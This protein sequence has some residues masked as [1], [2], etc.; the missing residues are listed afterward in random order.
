MFRRSQLWYCQ[1]LSYVLQTCPKS[2][3]IPRPLLLVV[4]YIKH[5]DSSPHRLIYAHPL[6]HYLAICSSSPWSPGFVSNSSITQISLFLP[7]LLQAVLERM[8]TWKVLTSC[9]WCCK[10]HSQV[11]CTF[12]VA[13]PCIC[14][15][16]FHIPI[17]LSLCVYRRKE[18]L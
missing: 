8:N 12:P 7:T 4:W 6:L 3:I 11:H 14:Y 10:Y 15:I 18:G 9:F 17:S 16:V 1:F 5:P 2:A 13:Y